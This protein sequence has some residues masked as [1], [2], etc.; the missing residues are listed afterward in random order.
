MSSTDQLSLT[1]CMAKNGDSRI[2]AV[3]ITCAVI[4]ALRANGHMGV[5]ELANEL[6]YSKST[7][8]YHLTTLQANQL[9]VREQDNFR[10]S[11]HFLELAHDAKKQYGLTH[12]SIIREKVNEL[13]AETGERV[14]FGSE[15]FGELVSM[16]RSQHNSSINEHFELRIREPMH[17]TASGKAMLAFMSQED[18]DEIVDTHGLEPK[19]ENTI[20]D[21]E[22]LMGELEEIREQ[23]FAI[24][25]EERATGLRCIA[26]PIIE[27]RRYDSV[28]VGSISIS[29]P[30]SRLSEERLNAE[31]TT[32]VKQFANLIEIACNAGG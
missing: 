18:V 27:N 9:V 13:S 23:G 22:E 3:D 20:T 2:Q 12:Y 17:C 15:E 14:R 16:Y 10:L 32:K 1:D 21:Y 8:H 11:L 30:V 26:A 28:V 5:S 29:G 24:D 31:L 7:I 4:E 6:E 25:H 19:T